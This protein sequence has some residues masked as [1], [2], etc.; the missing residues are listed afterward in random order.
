[1]KPLYLHVRPNTSIVVNA[2]RHGFY[3]QNYDAEG[4]ERIAKQ[5]KENH[6]V[7]SPRTRNAIISDA[8]AVALIDKLEYETL[9]DLLKYAKDEEELLPWIDITVGL[10][11]ILKYFGN[12]PESKFAKSY[13]MSILEPIYKKSS[14]DYLVNNFKNDSLFFE[15]KQLLDAYCHFGSKECIG[16]YSDLFVKH[17][18]RKCKQGHKASECVKVA[19]PLRAMVYCYG[20]KEG[21]DEAFNKVMELYNAETVQL[22]KDYLLRALGCH[23][24]ITALK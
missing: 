2:D 22:E 23:K 19:A 12:E 3:R 8:F 21:G 1:D 14:I 4:W 7:Y 17:V 13:M 10:Y 11:S 5:L 15:K 24:D 20:V 9:F 16:Q 18:S 6:K